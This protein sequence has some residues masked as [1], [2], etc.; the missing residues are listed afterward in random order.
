MGGDVERGKE[1]GVWLRG[2]VAEDEVLSIDRGAVDIDL[3]RDSGFAGAAGR[4]ASLSELFE[5]FK[6]GD[7][8]IRSVERSAWA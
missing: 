3:R 5:L 4:C 8:D 6:L 1:V 7:V 2:G